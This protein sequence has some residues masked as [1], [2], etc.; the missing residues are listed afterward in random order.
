M[1]LTGMRVHGVAE[2]TISRGRV[3]WENGTLHTVRGSGA[4]RLCYG[5]TLCDFV[6]NSSHRTVHF[7]HLFRARGVR[8][9]VLLHASSDV[10]LSFNINTDCM[11]LSVKCCLWWRSL[12]KCHN[13]FLHRYRRPR[14]SARRAQ[15]QSGARAVQGRSVGA[16]G[17][18]VNAE[19]RS[20]SGAALQRVTVAIRT[21]RC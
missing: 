17:E 7:A 4:Q 16:A 10:E 1:L 12:H 14:R 13:H 18:K 21:R 19:N 20:A 9:C 6:A 2:I 8:R 15:A 3:V 11:I 5:H